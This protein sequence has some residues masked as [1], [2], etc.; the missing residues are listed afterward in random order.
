MTEG[1]REVGSTSFTRRLERLRRKRV[2]F[3][4]RVRCQSRSR[5]V[6]GHKAADIVVTRPNSSCHRNTWL[7]RH[8]VNT[9]AFPGSPRTARSLCRWS[10]GG[11]RFGS[12]RRGGVLDQLGRLAG[13]TLLA[14]G[15]RCG[16]PHGGLLA[17]CSPGVGAVSCTGTLGSAGGGLGAASR[18]AAG[19][20]AGH[21]CRV[22]TACRSSRVA[23]VELE[24]VVSRRVETSERLIAQER[25]LAASEGART[26]NRS[27]A[28][29][30]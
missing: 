4:R 24:A 25:S 8:R 13:V 23:A 16:W 1:N 21:R 17:E 11:T 10:A 29:S 30:H 9:L 6:R 15:S 18:S 26:G 27:R 19:H 3:G 2:D 14:T 22:L 7:M 20:L 5:H 28:Q 12:V